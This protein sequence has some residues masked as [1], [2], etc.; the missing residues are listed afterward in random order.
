MDPEK[1]VVSPDEANAE[2]EALTEVK[3]DE[4]RTRVI[5][6]LGLADDDTNKPV[7][8]KIVERE[9][10]HK[11][12]LSEA[13]GQK[14]K[15]RDQ[16]KIAKPVTPTRVEATPFTPDDIRKQTEVT[17]TATLEQRDLDEMEYSDEIKTDIKRVAQ[18]QGISVRK[19]AQDPYVQFKIAQASS[20]DRVTEAAVPRTQKTTPVST[21]KIPKFDLATEDGRKDYD[22]W[23]QSR[24]G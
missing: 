5:S 19:A 4:V 12:K 24:K 2:Q 21:Q 18:L 8:D 9:L 15:W 7:I 17:V 11:K 1:V 22:A 10:S 16:V 6:D 13:I 23:K 3:A 14:I 20:A